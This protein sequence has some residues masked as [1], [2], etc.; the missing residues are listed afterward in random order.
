MCLSSSSEQADSSASG[1]CNE[2]R[3][4]TFFRDLLQLDAQGASHFGTR[5]RDPKQFLC[6]SEAEL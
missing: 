6:V 4:I 5:R 3:C 2:R 1:E